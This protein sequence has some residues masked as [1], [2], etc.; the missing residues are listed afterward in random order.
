MTG[1]QEIFADRSV[2]LPANYYT[3]LSPYRENAGS[4]KEDIESAGSVK[5]FAAGFGNPRFIPYR[6]YLE[7]NGILT[8]FSGNHNVVAIAGI[9]TRKLT[10]ILRGESAQAVVSWLADIILKAAL[11]VHK[12]FRDR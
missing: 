12:L 3:D 9:D 11:H 7:K 10:R 2:L 6:K 4:N 5:V 1:Y 8:N